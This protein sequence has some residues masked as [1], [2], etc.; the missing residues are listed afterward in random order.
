VFSI[1]LT[2]RRPAFRIAAEGQKSGRDEVLPMT[3]DFAE[4]LVA[5][6]PEAERTGLVFRLLDQRTHQPLTVHQ[7]GRVVGKIGR[8]AG[9]VTNK[10]EGKYAGLHDLRRA[11]CTRWAKREMPAVLRRLARHS[12]ITTTLA[13]YVDLDAAEVADGLWAKHEA[14]GAGQAEI[15]GNTVG[16]GNSFGNIGP[17]TALGA[18]TREST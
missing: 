4:W 16:A 6:F 18:G 14:K 7:I 10:A 13:Y 1:D 3:P 17:E 15:P 2:G 11:F 8:K 12:S 5:A 9:V